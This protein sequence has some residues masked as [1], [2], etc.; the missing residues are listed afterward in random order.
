MRDRS[1]QSLSPTTAIWPWA[2]IADS[3]APC[4]VWEYPNRTGSVTFG[5]SCAVGSLSPCRFSHLVLAAAAFTS[6]L[7]APV[8]SS[9]DEHAPSP[10]A[11]P[12]TAVIVTAFVEVF[13][14][15]ASRVDV[16]GLQCVENPG[17]KLWR[18]GDKPHTDGH[19]HYSCLVTS[20]DTGLTAIAVD[21]HHRA[22]NDQPHH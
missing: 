19:F 6:G 20:G 9:S 18:G 7:S 22:E 13:M 8:A 5:P 3:T 14:L 4:G 12:T 17:H 11:R 21:S 10:K 16:S 1:G 2:L 15:S